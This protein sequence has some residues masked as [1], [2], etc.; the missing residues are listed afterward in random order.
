MKEVLYNP[1]IHNF[2]KQLIF[3]AEKLDIVDV[4][5]DL[6]LVHSLFEL[7]WKELHGDEPVIPF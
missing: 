2:A 1:D 7:Q 5:S 3:T 6:E 4:L